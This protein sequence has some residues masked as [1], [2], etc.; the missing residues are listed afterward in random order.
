VKFL[1][2]KV[3]V[4]LGEIILRILDYTVTISS[5]YILNCGC[6]NL[7]CGCFNLFCNVWVC[8][9]VGFCKVWLRVCVGL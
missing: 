7:Y 4:H 2:I 8:V 6:C 1:V 3:H 9:C 5:G